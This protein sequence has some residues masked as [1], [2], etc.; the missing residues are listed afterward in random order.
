LAEVVSIVSGAIDPARLEEVEDR[1]TKAL[2][3]GPPA[4]IEETFLLKAD[5]GAIAVVSVWRRREDLRATLASGEEPFA[6]RLIREAGGTP[7]AQ[8]F[9]I[10]ARAT[11]ASD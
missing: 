11:P 2:K 8:I 7:N 9:E 4:A 3:D 1:Y 6:R 5:D 10:I